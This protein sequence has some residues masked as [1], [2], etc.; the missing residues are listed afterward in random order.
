MMLDHVYIPREL[1]KAKMNAAEWAN[2]YAY[3]YGFKDFETGEDTSCFK[4]FRTKLQERKKCEKQKAE[5]H[6]R[7]MKGADKKMKGFKMIRK[8]GA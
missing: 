5:K 1:F 4:K 3:F 8:R 6:R 7:L 2:A